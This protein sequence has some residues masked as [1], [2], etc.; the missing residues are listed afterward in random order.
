MAA[1][2]DDCDKPLSK[3]FPAISPKTALE[4]SMELQD[5]KMELSQLECLLEIKQ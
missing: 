2:G 5:R 3:F 4:W 1:S